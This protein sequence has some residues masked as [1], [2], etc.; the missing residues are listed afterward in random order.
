MCKVLKVHPSGYYAWLKEPESPRAK[1]NKELLKKIEESYVLSNRTYGYR[2]IHKDLIELG[3]KVNKKRV[4]R[5]MK[6]QKLY[7]TGTV[8]FPIKNKSY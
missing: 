8:D 2:N 1:E 6:L 5:L 3:I 4:A 7:G